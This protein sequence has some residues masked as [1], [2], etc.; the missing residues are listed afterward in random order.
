MPFLEFFLL[1][2]FVVFTLFFYFYRSLKIKYD[3]L[4]TQHNDIQ[5]LIKSIPYAWCSWNLGEEQVICS[6]EF[7]RLLGLSENLKITLSDILKIFGKSPF[8]SFNKSLEHLYSFGGEFCLQVSI[9]NIAYDLEIKGRILQVDQHN[10]F[11]QN[12]ND[13]KQVVILSLRDVTD[14]NLEQKKLETTQKKQNFE[15]ELFYNL[16]KYV[17]I[18]FW[19]RDY[20]GRLSY[21]NQIYADVLNTTVARVTAENLELLPDNVEHGSYKLF[22]AA[23]DANEKQSIRYHVVL[24]GER[25]LLEFTEIP[26]KGSKKITIGYA[27]D[28]TDIEKMENELSFFEK[29]QREFLN[30]LSTPIASYTSDGRLDFFNSAYVKTF[31]LNES[32]LMTKPP[33]TEV[34]DELRRKRAIPEYSDFLAH[35]NDRLK[36][37]NNLFEPINEILY[38]PNGQVLRMTT[39]PNT[40]GGGLSYIFEDITDKIALERGYNTLMAVQKETIDNLYEGILVLGSD[41]KIRIFNKAFKNL[42]NVEDTFSLERSISDIFNNRQ[43]IF[44]SEHEFE[45]CWQSIKSILNDRKSFSGVFCLNMDKLIEYSYVPLPDGSHLLNFINISDSYK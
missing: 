27:V 14:F 7:L 10:Q 29:S 36:L 34:L 1:I 21:C 11:A 13:K 18:V 32:W 19:A 8:C 23:L 16:S 17:P 43:I 6:K 31:H 37:F 5:N 39:I 35:K 28:I 42:W 3:F 22:Q 15:L 12:S 45:S 33:L 44:C 41:Y 4:V 24:M 26:I 25:R 30:H 40:F 38:Q 20:Q 2:I 9:D